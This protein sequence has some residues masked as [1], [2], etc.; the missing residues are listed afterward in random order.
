MDEQR[1]EIATN[2]RGPV[3]R[4]QLMGREYY[5][6]P[7]TLVRSQILQN[8]LGRTYL[9]ASDIT[10][11]WAESSNG[12]PAVAEHP[13]VSARSPEVLNKLGVGFL[14]NAKAI[15]GALKADVYLDPARA[16]DVPDLRAVLAKLDAGERVEVSTGFQVHIDESP[17]VHNG[18]AYDRVIHPATPLDHLAVFA[19]AT[20]ACSVAD[21]CGLAANHAGPCET[22]GAVD[23]ATQSKLSQALDRLVAFLGGS[24]EDS[25]A[26]P[27]AEPTPE[28]GS[29]MNREQMIAQLAEAGPLG[30]DALNKLS[31]CQLKALLG[32]DEPAANARPSLPPETTTDSEVL[33]I[34]HQYRRENEELRAR[35]Q[36]AHNEQEKERAR[37]MDDLLYA[38]N[39]LPYTPDEIREMDVVEMRKVHALAFPR[40][41]DYS[42]RG[43]P[44]AENRGGSFDFVAGIMDGPRGTSVLDKKEVN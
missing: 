9:P 20:G 44:A 5:A 22:E 1:I 25:P 29:T 34:A 43:G 23:E 24:K 21:G 31:D 17:G 39:N 40:R 36:P 6:V 35:Y 37:L 26:D 32:A 41:T 27:A 19:E 38:A 11:E 8:N 4:A 2:L 30:T 28:E 3:R 16:G 18:E 12:A 10:P 14:F 33:K 15:E 7:A 13:N 42:L